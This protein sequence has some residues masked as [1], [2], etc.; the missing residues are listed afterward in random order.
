V[1]VFIKCY[2][3]TTTEYRQQTGNKPA[4][5]ATTTS[6]TQSLTDRPAAD[7]YVPEA[8]HR[9]EV[10]RSQQNLKGPKNVWNT[11][12]E[13]FTPKHT[14]YTPRYGRVMLYAYLGAG[15]VEFDD[16]V[17]KQILPGSPS[18]QL[19]QRRHSMES[20]VTIEEMRENE[21]R[22]REAR[23]RLRQG[24]EDQSNEERNEKK[25]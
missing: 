4:T 14:K 3:D 7:D 21:Q 8:L 18:E 20:S 23:Q 5:P 9:R 12:T 11:H 22:G 19:K 17:L 25:E 1:K 13:D 6:K 2:D 16:V 24:E 15:V 10:Y